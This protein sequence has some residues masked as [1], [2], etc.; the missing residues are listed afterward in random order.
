MKYSVNKQLTV[1]SGKKAKDRE[2]ETAN[3]EQIFS[4]EHSTQ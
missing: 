1:S 2:T 3:Q 4:V